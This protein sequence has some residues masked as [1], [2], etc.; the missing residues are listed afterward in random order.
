M[1]ENTKQQVQLGQEANTTNAT[2]ASN[3][4]E[5]SENTASALPTA[6]QTAANTG[7]AAS[8]TGA[9]LPATQQTASNTA[10]IANC[11]SSG[12]MSGGT[13][14]TTTA[15]GTTTAPTSAATPT[16]AAP[17]TTA[18]T[19]SGGTT[20]TYSSRNNTVQNVNLSKN[21]GTATGGGRINMPAYQQGGFALTP[22]VATIAEGGPE[23]VLPLGNAKRFFEIIRQADPRG[24]DSEE[25]ARENG[26]RSAPERGSGQPVTVQVDNSELKAEMRRQN[27]LIAEQNELLR[28]LVGGGID[29]SDGTLSTIGAKFGE[30][31]EGNL[32]GRAGRDASKQHREW[33]ALEMNASGATYQY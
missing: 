20:S 19:A 9:A 5:I 27:A 11:C 23:M 12:G 33:E 17:S 1:G 15:D 8:N 25:T 21:T 2:N 14:P 32:R 6:Q 4:G 28:A 16:T 13:T 10:S 31:V 22:Q 29:L 24:Y 18:P 7:T 30:G 26:V 3:T